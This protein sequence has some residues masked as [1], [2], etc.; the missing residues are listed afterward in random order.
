M[1]KGGDFTVR[2]LDLYC[3]AVAAGRIVERLFSICVRHKTVA[4]GVSR[5]PKKI[6]LV[7]FLDH[8]II[9]LVLN[10]GKGVGR[11]NIGKD[12]VIADFDVEN[13]RFILRD[14]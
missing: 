6:F 5:E 8:G 12:T 3:Y 4:I 1:A 7:K 13:H 9:S 14:Q 11:I 10:V 2:H